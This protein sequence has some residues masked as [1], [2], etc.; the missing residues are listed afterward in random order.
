MKYLKKFETD[1]QYVSYIQGGGVALPNVSLCVNENEVHYNPIVIAQPLIATYNVEDASN[2]T[3]LF[4]GVESMGFPA[5]AIYDKIEI[6]NVEIDMSDLSSSEEEGE[7]VYSYQLTSGE[8]TVKYTL[9]D[10]TMIGV[11]I[12]EG[13]SMPKI[14]ATFM[15]C[16]ITSIEIPNSVTNIGQNAFAA[17]SGLTSVIIPNSVTS[18][19]TQAFVMC[20]N[21]EYINIPDSVTSI[22]GSAF[23]SCSGLTSVTIGNSVTSIGEAAFEECSSLPSVTIPNSVTSIGEAA[24]Y[25]CRS[26][27]SVTIPNS[28]TN[29]SDSTFY[30]C[31]SLPSVTIPNSVTSIGGHAFWNCNTLRSVTIP[32]SVTSI[33][34]SAF[35][36]LRL[37]VIYAT[38]PPSED[39]FFQP[40]YDGNDIVTVVQVP[41]EAVNTY[42]ATW[43]DYAEIIEAIPTT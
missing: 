2:P 15:N 7:T 41:S 43:S 18:I 36:A 39:I 37:V 25:N 29:I 5:S 21:L 14:G 20:S 31:S 32:N 3:P 28:V 4:I 13:T 24:F 17:C 30:N 19:G 38:T 26:L 35:D 34:T 9:K 22:G 42:K 12:D 11:E 10:P 1:S 16:P 6:D 40:L 27:T 8:H 23:S 33:D